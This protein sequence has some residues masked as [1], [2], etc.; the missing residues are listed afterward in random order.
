MKKILITGFEP[1]GEEQINPSWDAVCL[2]PS[3]IGEYTLTKL[4]VPVVFGAAFETVINEA[5]KI[6]PD[7]ILCVGQAGGRSDITAELV[8]I[9]L[10]HATISDNSGICP[11]DEPIDKEGKTAYFST[12]P[13]R[14]IAKSIEDAGIPAKVS[15][16]AGAYV[17]N[18][19]LYTLLAKYE[20]TDTKIGFIHVP[21]STAQKKE[22][23]M[24]IEKI[25]TGL[26]IA[27]EN[28]DG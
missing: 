24:D 15:Y 3:K 9:N 10:R 11:K 23:S 14:K 6:N 7:V 25:V 28:I 21:Y 1:F 16:T 4:L 17:C 12:L 2:L 13:V 27:I 20:N 22:P 18:D 26:T 19:L 8:A 5:K